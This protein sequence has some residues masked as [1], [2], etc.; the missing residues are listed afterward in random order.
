MTGRDYFIADLLVA[1]QWSAVFRK[2]VLVVTAAL[3]MSAG[4]PAQALCGGDTVANE[5]READVVVRARLVS[6]IEA[7]DDEPSAAFRSR[8]GDGSRVILYGLRV[9]EVFK[10]GPS[11]RIQFFEERNSGAF[12]LDVDR[13]YL[14]FLYYIHPYRGRPSAARGAMYV[15]YAC[16]QSKLWDSVQGHDLATLRGLSTRR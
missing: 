13:D 16:G 8:W 9:R 4:T 10:G 15:K 11:R 7:W 12:Y 3:F 2:T 14:L 1:K 5:F 6:Q